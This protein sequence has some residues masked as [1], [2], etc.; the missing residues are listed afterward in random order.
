MSRYGD[1]T[2][3]EAEALT[4]IIV[5][6]L[7]AGPLTQPELRKQILPKVGKKMKRYM[8]LAWSIQTFRPALVQGLICYGPASG[9]KATFVRADQWLPKQKNVSEL[10]AKKILLR[11][12]LSA[13][14]PATVRDFSKWSGIPAPEAKPLWQSLLDELVEV[15][16]GDQPTSLLRED[17]AALAASDIKD[18]VVRLLPYFDPYLLG[19][20]DTS[21]MVKPTHYKKVYRNQ[22]WI[23]P[24]VLLDGRVIGI[25]SH[26]QRGKKLSIEVETF[27]RFSKAIRTKIENEAENIGN[28]LETSYDIDFVL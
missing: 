8:E 21:P 24:V 3:E 7:H 11:R 6:A 12:Y 19:H 14:G 22:G 16:V 2:V 23:S 27:E 26:K 17:Y 1:V 25:W 28:F 5:E 18:Q 15:S 10:E 9:K 20:A 13:Y 4:E